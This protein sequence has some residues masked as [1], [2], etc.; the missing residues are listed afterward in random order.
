MEAVA[1]QEAANQ[2]EAAAAAVEKSADANEETPLLPAPEQQR[3]GDGNGSGSGSHVSFGSVNVHKHRMTMGTNPFTSIGVPVELAWEE[4]SSETMPVDAF[5]RS[6]PPP[7]PRRLKVRE[8]QEIAEAHHTRD[9]IERRQEE[10]HEAQRSIEASG[11]DDDPD[12][13]LWRRRRRR[14]GTTT[15]PCCIIS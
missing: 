5:E 14:G 3:I 10:V 9:S 12:R 1:V 2:D 13:P 11:R 6:H 7:P 8:R 15:S 4:E